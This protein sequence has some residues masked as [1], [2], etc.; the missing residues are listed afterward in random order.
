MPLMDVA[1]KLAIQVTVQEPLFEKW[2]NQRAIAAFRMPWKWR[3]RQGG[4]CGLSV[5]IVIGLIVKLP[6]ENLV[7]GIALSAA[8][9]A[10]V[11]QRRVAL[12]NRFIGITI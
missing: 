7:Y 8:G 6:R 10:G 3:Y 2:E 1:K 4:V 5:S 11:V 12:T 9:G